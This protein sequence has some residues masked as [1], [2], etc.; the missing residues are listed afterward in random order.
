MD[1]TNN[2]FFD[3]CKVMGSQGEEA[4]KFFLHQLIDA[5][6]YL[7]DRN[8]IHRDLKLENLLID[9][10]LNIKIVD[11]GFAVKGNISQLKNSVG[12]PSYAAPE[13]HEER[14]YNGKEI[15]IFSLGVIIYSVVTGRKPFWYGR[16]NDDIYNL[17]KTGQ[18]ETYFKYA[19]IQ[20]LSDE[21]KDLM[22]RMFAYEGSQRPTIEEIR[23]HPWMYRNSIKI[24]EVNV[25]EVKGGQDVKK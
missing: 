22:M 1:Y 12:T 19:G 18:Y 9:A 3:F 25:T 21:F 15:D 6:G 11:F 24:I 13:V 5:L 14:T 2:D 23:N 20:D 8:V 17:I 7:H 4:G 16:S 10:D